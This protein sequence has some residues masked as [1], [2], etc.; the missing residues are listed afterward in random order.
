MK[1]SIYRITWSPP[2]RSPVVVEGWANNK[3]HACRMAFRE[4]IRQGYMTNQ[5]K[6]T[7][8]TNGGFEHTAVEVITNE[9]E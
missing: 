5:P 8:D 7:P 4:M 1:R 3:N 9:R 6:T 2:H